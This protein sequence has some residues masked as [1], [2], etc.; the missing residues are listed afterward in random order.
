ML[1]KILTLCLVL[2]MVSL[3]AFAALEDIAGEKF[4]KE[5]SLLN[6]IGI[7]EGKEAN[8]YKPADKLT[9]AE[10]TTIVLRLLTV[11]ASIPATFEDVAADHWASKI[12]GSAAQLGIVNGMSATTFA[13]EENVTY[14][15][16]AKM[17]VC[18]LGYGVAAEAMGGWPTG[19][20]AQASQLGILKGTSDDGQPINRA[21]MA[22]MVAN[23]LEVDLMVRTGYGSEMTFEP[24]EGANLLNEYL[25]IVVLKGTI[26]ANYTL[27]LGG[28][29]CEENEVAMGDTVMEVGET[30]IASFIGREVTVYARENEEEETLTALCVEPKKNSEVFTI[31]AE[32]VLPQTTATELWYDADGSKEFFEINAKAKWVYN[33]SL[34]NDPVDLTNV[35]GSITLSANDGER[36]DVVFVDAQQDAVVQKVNASTGVVTF[37]APILNAKGS[38]IRNI[39][40]DADNKSVKFSITDKDGNA[41]AV[42]DLK[43]WDVL[44]I[45]M[46]NEQT[47]YQIVRSNDTITGKITEYSVTDESAKIGDAT[48]DIAATLVDVNGKAVPTTTKLE[49]K[50]FMN[51]LGK[52]VAADTEGIKEYKYGYIVAHAAGTGID[53]TESV[54]IFTED[55]EMKVFTLNKKYTKSEEINLAEES[56]LQYKLNAAGEITELKYM[57]PVPGPYGD[58]IGA[59]TLAWNYRYKVLESTKIFTVPD[60]YTGNDS[61][62]GF[63]DHSLLTNHAS[64]PNV[65]LYDL[66]EED[67]IGV[68]LSRG[69]SAACG[70]VGVVS[71]VSEALNNDEPVI[72]VEVI[73]WRSGNTVALDMK[74]GTTD[75]RY[76]LGAFTNEKEVSV[77]TDTNVKT[78]EFD[79][80]Y[81]GLEVGDVIWYAPKNVEGYTAAVQVVARANHQRTANR[82][83]AFGD[84]TKR[85]CA[86][87]YNTEDKF[88]FAFVDTIKSIS[89][90]YITFENKD[91][92]QDELVRESKELMNS[93]CVILY[94]MER[95]TLTRVLPDEIMEDDNLVFASNTDKPL[96]TV[97]YRNVPASAQTSPSAE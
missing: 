35:N 78:L 50:F 15:Q 36:A 30:N 81:A 91:F 12:I 85:Y 54:K 44:T 48:Y 94:D 87:L 90:Q 79:G 34:V 89:N 70:S 22:K 27:N 13:P 40:L 18:T 31:D 39:T 84:S 71:K 1:K 47:L 17:L 73:A 60:E 92:E 29:S 59:P 58:F 43:E 28:A 11:D 97:I 75:I 53:A 76:M 74:E 26:D 68:A 62:Y 33:G 37:K 7:V 63:F 5:I 56:L 9:R 86:Y 6:S 72:R 83:L 32:D 3:P 24:K 77:R 51:Y 96:L 49:A 10:M 16:A 64:V 41:V 19:Y 8:A 14:P 65:Q 69:V 42:K 88:N 93:E 4:E 20:L 55:G 82:G 38:E 46:N 2:C 25:D 23:S 95:G 57:E 67:N 66:D 45:T 61:L 80:G 21:V 52:V